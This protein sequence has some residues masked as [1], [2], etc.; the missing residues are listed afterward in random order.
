V[1]RVRPITSKAVRVCLL[2]TEAVAAPCLRSQ[3]DR[4][5]HQGT[6]IENS[7]HL[8]RSPKI[9]FSRHDYSCLPTGL[10]SFFLLH[11]SSLECRPECQRAHQRPAALPSWDD[12]CR[13]RTLT[14]WINGP[15]HGARGAVHRTVLWVAAFTIHAPLLSAVSKAEAD[16]RSHSRLCR[17]RAVLGTQIS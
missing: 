4:P 12:L 2:S 11:L 8:R 14:C 13:G 3:Y 5:T 9:E 10:P 16:T 15:C 17:R 6:R 1:A 7:P